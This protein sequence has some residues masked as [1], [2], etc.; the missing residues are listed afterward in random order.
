MIHFY[1]HYY[2]Y[3]RFDTLSLDCNDHLF[4]YDGGHAAGHPKVIFLILQ[5]CRVKKMK[6]LNFVLFL[7]LFI[8]YNLCTHYR[9]TSPVEIQSNRWAYCSQTQIISHLSMLRTTG[10][11]TQ[12]ASNL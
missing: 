10:E 6:T 1:Y 9:L 7:F 11:L 3:C 4:V 2:Y 8:I 12:M 5:C